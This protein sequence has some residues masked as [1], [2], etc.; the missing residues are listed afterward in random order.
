MC[1]VILLTTVF[2]IFLFFKQKT[3]YE[4]RIS[5]WSSDV[6]SSDLPYEFTFCPS[7]VTS[8][9]PSSTSI[10]ISLRMS[11]GRRSFSLPRRLGTMQN[12][13]VLLHPT[14]M[15]THPLDA[16]SR[17]VGRVEGQISSDSMISSSASPFCRARSRRPG[18]VPLFCLPPTTPTH[19]PFSSTPCLSTF[20]SH[21]PTLPL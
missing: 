8:I 5:D 11:P 10:R 20:S 6:C 12:V 21:P 13:H 7:R 18:R 19:C 4:M 3:A 14:E 1:I 16:E 17:L 9:A 2:G 15:A